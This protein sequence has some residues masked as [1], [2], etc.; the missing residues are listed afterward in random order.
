MRA[1]MACCRVASNGRGSMVAS[2]CPFFTICPSVKAIEVITPETWGR[3]VTVI[4]GTTVPSASSTTGRSARVAM[5]M[6]TV[7]APKRLP[8]PAPPPGP[9]GP[10][11]PGARRIGRARAGGHGGERAARRRRRPMRQVPGE[12]AEAD[13]RDDRD[14]GTEPA[15]SGRRDTVVGRGRIVVRIGS[16]AGPGRRKPGRLTRRGRTRRVERTAGQ[17]AIGM[18]RKVPP[19]RRRGRRS[20]R[21]DVDGGFWRKLF[22]TRPVEAFTPH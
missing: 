16:H 20:G 19:P 12:R 9:P 21:S 10:A 4:E 14:D 17:P 5:A 6:P 7:L 2:N 11:G 15:P 3:T 8:R 13:Q 22:F 1:P 18:L